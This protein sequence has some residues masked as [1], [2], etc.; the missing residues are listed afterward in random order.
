VSQGKLPRRSALPTTMSEE[1]DI[2]AAAVEG[3][4]CRPGAPGE[5]E[6]PGRHDGDGG[7]RRRQ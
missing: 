2:A 3:V 7:E 6:E 1:L 5:G 4:T